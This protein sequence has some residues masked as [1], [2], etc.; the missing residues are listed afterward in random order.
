MGPD[1]IVGLCM[2]RSVD[3]VVALVAVLK[4]GGAYLP[5]DLAYPKDRLEFMLDDSQARVLLTQTNLL[6]SL[7]STGATIVCVDSRDPIRNARPAL[8]IERP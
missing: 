5:I 4:A 1:V 6:A 3:L 8:M 7:P 2:E